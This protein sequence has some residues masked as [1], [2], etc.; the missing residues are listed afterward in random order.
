ME[1]W[2]AQKAEHEILKGLI[3]EHHGDLIDVQDKIL[4]LFK[5]KASVKGGVT[6]IGVTKKA[7]PLL[8]KGLVTKDNAKYTY[9]IE[10]GFDAWNMLSNRQKT[11]QLDH[12]LCAMAVTYDNEDFPK[13]GI[14][15][16]DF[17]AYRG[18]IER[19][20]FWHPACEEDSTDI[21]EKIFGSSSKS[22]EAE[23]ATSLP[24]FG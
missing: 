21:V 15:P 13:Y 16:A 17:S 8:A 2:K 22:D 9:I 23:N 18:E 20:G 24:D 6:T 14:K 12:C 5:E 10:L 11:A 19:W 3:N 1:I 4:I 7:P